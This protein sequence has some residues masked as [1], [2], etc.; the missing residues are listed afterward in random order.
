LSSYCSS[1]LA[2][3][4]LTFFLWGIFFLVYFQLFPFPEYA[5]MA[6]PSNASPFYSELCDRT[7]VPSANLEEHKAGTIHRGLLEALIK[8]IGHQLQEDLKIGRCKEKLPA[9]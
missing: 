7:L 8:M 3:F 6:P 9:K 1:I 5:P 4:F 2:G